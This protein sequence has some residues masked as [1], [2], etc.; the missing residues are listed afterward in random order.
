MSKNV[1]IIVFSLIALAVLGGVA[2]VLMLTAPENKKPDTK[3]KE[4]ELF[5]QP[6]TSVSDTVLCKREEADVARVEVTNADGSYTI[7]PKGEAGD[8]GLQVWTV[9]GMG[10]APIESSSV[11]GAVT[12]AVQFTAKEFAEEAADSSVLAKYGLDKPKATV[13]AVFTD[14]G[15]FSFSIG[16]DVP[17]SSTS[18]Y[19]TADGKNVYTCYKS[20]MESFLKSRY[21][22]VKLKAFPD[23]DQSSGEEV[24]KI[25]VK[26]RDLD[27]PII[28]ESIAPDSEDEI[29][30]FSYR[31]VSPY[32]VYADL[33][34]APTFMYSIFGLN[35]ASCEWTGMEE[36]DFEIAGLND[37]NCV[38]TVETD[39]KTYTLTLGAATTEA[40]TDEDGNEKEKITGFFGVSSEVP[41]VLY[42][43]TTDAV[44]AL[45]I[46]PDQLI[47]RLFLMPYIYTL[48]SVK[49]TDDDGRTL[50]IGF[51]TI[52][53]ASEEE[54]DQHTYTVNGE[55]AEEQRVKDIYQFFISASGDELYFDSEKGELLAEIVYTYAD[56]SDGMDGKDVVRFYSS[57]TDRKI[58]IELNGQ[59]MFKMKQMYLTQLKSNV[60]RFFSGEEIVDSY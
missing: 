39:R 31:L 29:Q 20:R 53:A 25:T 42:R 16:N 3:S 48:D 58:I 7:E 60:D 45:S 59:V 54:E 56:P 21:G 5:S 36:R 28:I 22:Y 6:E 50:D 41:G 46:M 23:Y 55:P 19:V 1:K 49:Y 9:A 27:E 10:D 33:K 15:E 4:E 26:R 2:A 14:G 40:Y 51:T 8:G 34:D 12:N 11:S 18:V 30:V 32:T 37:P 24:K 43:F 52:P 47:S 38:F 57:D 13:K 17:N 44:P 35:A